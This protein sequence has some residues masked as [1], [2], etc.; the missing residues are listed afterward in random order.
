MTISSVKQVG[1]DNGRF[2]RILVTTDFSEGTPDALNY[3][4]S[5]AQESQARVT[6]LHV[7]HDTT[8]HYRPGRTRDLERKLSKLVPDEVKEW[9]VVETKLDTGTPYQR[10]LETANRKR[11]DLLVMNI[12]GKGMLSRALLGTNAERVVRAA[13]CPVL[14]IPPMPKQAKKARPKKREA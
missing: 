2:K 13:A 6:L 10:I 11:I 12:H 3:A 8:I 7:V 9:C 1:I 14:L 4:F 5:I